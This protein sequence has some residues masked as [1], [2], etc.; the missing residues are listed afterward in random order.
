MKKLIPSLY[1]QEHGHTYYT[2][3]NGK[4]NCWGLQKLIGYDKEGRPKYKELVCDHIKLALKT[5]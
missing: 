5:S 3:E 4:C 1:P 2:V